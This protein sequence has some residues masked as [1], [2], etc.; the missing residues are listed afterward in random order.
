MYHRWIAEMSSYEPYNLVNRSG[1]LHRNA[2]GM[3]RARKD[4]KFMEC[5]SCAYHHK[6]NDWIRDSESMDS[7]DEDIDENGKKK[8]EDQ[9]DLARE[10][11]DHN[12]Y[13]SWDLE[14]LRRKAHEIEW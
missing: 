5:E 11:P 6:R 9:R 3:S 7:L 4:C 2:D 12:D 1:E 14:L 10:A 13:A 8:T